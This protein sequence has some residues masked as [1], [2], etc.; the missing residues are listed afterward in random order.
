MLGMVTEYFNVP[1]ILLLS[2]KILTSLTKPVY[3]QNLS[4]ENLLWV[5]KLSDE[6]KIVYK[7]FITRTRLTEYNNYEI[8]IKKWLFSIFFIVG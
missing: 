5:F 2:F 6:V 8:F 7:Y 1:T 4:H 3:F